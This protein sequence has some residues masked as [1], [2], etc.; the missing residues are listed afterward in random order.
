MEKFTIIGGDERSLML[1]KLLSE[2]G[3]NVSIFGFDSIESDLRKA[4][5]LDNA[6]READILIGPLPFTDESGDLFT[7]LNTSKINIESI[8]SLMTPNQIF[9]GGRVK[10]GLKVVDYFK[11]EELQIFNAIPTA[12]GAVQV[13]FEEMKTTIFGSD[14]LI[15]G[16]GRIGK[17]LAKMLYSLG[18]N[19]YVAA[20]K[21]S[22][23][24]WIS[25]SGYNP[26]L[27]S[28]I[29]SILP[30]MN[31][32]FNTI[33]SLI[34]D[35]DKLSFL[36]KKSIVIDLA[37]KPGGVDFDSAKKMDIKAI[38]ALA[39]PGKVAPITAAKIIKDTIYNII[40]E[41]EV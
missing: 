23:I 24:A 16:Y 5:S 19:M 6:V 14:I 39:L 12:E 22:D 41:L 40:R 36:D 1:A 15:L 32:V 8:L 7:P 34:L 28:D 27:L 21:Y 38:H 33:P 4:T 3:M 37:S 20:R 26:I 31:V 29:D 18:A 9:L 25:S 2:D 17:I 11:R 10:D 30:N 35:K 13:A